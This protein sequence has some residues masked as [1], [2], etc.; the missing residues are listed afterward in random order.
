MRYGPDSILRFTGADSHM[1]ER[2][3]T[4]R[5]VKTKPPPPLSAPPRETG[6]PPRRPLLLFDPP[7]RIEVIASVPDGPPRRFFWRGRSYVASRHE[8]PERI[9]PEWWR[10]PGGHGDNPG[11]TRDYY[12]VEDDAGHRFWLFRRG[13]Y[14][15]DLPAPLPLAGGAG[16]E[17]GQGQ[18]GKEKGPPLP[19]PASGR[20]RPRS[21]PGVLTLPEWYI[22]G[23]FA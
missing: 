14:E 20:G 21:N 19:P 15:T 12:R 16:G 18:R 23:L 13:L 5:P 11:F 1:P 4:L 2:A 6:E 9:A 10:R 17:H 8:G 7:Q 3:G 22:H